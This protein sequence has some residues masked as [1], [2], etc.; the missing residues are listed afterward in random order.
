MRYA[1]KMVLV[2]EDMY[3]KSLIQTHAR[4][5]AAPADFVLSETPQD[6]QINATARTLSQIN[7]SNKTPADV[8]QILYLQ[9]ARFL[10]TLLN[11]KELRALPVDLSEESLARLT[12]AAS[13]THDPNKSIEDAWTNKK[14]RKQQ[15]NQQ[16]V[17]KRKRIQED[18]QEEKARTI[19]IDDNNKSEVSSNFFP[20]NSTPS[21][22]S[23]RSILLSS[24]ITEDKEK[25]GELDAEEEGSLVTLDDL[26]VYCRKNRKRFG[27]N[28]QDQVVPIGQTNPIRNSNL[29]KVLTYA[30]EP[31]T[32]RKKYSP[33]GFAML[34]ARLAK[35]P[36]LCDKLS[37]PGT[38][39]NA[40]RPPVTTHSQQSY[41]ASGSGKR[42]GILG[43]FRP[44]L[45]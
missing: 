44:Q 10:Q 18:E 28:I 16:H 5:D 9:Q 2:P 40:T 8:K 43:A 12:A 4:V 20:I 25:N 34:M 1:N 24:S 36:Y 23:Q 42:H 17:E 27:I 37:L 45:W 19:P 38:S 21:S 15:L 32:K 35:D 29:R 6:A 30:L 11:D 41:K 39:A 7:N 31:V 26:V 13:A 3:R 14:K 22:S 33:H